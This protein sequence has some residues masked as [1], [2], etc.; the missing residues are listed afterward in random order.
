MTISKLYRVEI[1]VNSLPTDLDRIVDETNQQVS[2]L[3]KYFFSGN[4]TLD[5]KETNTIPFCAGWGF[6][7]VGF[8]DSV[9]HA[10]KAD[11][12]LKYFIAQNCKHL[13]IE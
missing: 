1:S 10:F 13:F 8:A 6:T 9:E 4:I 3:D 12:K 2:K 11:N 7:M 5:E